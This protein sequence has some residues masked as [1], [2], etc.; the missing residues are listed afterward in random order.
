MKKRNSVIILFITIILVSMAYNRFEWPQKDVNIKDT[1]NYLEV[2]SPPIPLIVGVREGPAVIDPIDSWDSASTNVIKQVAECLWWYNLTDP[3]LPLEGLLATAWNY[4]ANNKVLDVH[5]RESV[6]FHDGSVLN[7]TVVKWNLERINYFI[8]ATG[9]LPPTTVPAFP[10]SIYFLP[11]GSSIMKSVEVLDDYLVRITLNDV[12]ASFIPLMSYTGSAMISMVS[13]SATEYIDLTTDDL[14]GTGPFVYDGYETDIEVNFH[15]FENYWNGEA[16]IT[17]LVFKV[18]YESSIRNNAMLNKEIHFLDGVDPDFVD[19]FN[20]D[21]DIVNVEVGPDLIYW[22]YAFDTWR[23][24]VTWR[25][26][27]SKAYNYTYVIEE[28]R[29]G[30]AVR[31][32]P[33]VPSGMPGHDPTVVVAQYNIAEARLIMQS[34]GFGVGWDI[35]THVAG[36]FTPGA[37][38]ALWEAANFRH[39]EMNH[40]Q[41]SGNSRKLN[42][43]LTYDLNRIGVTTNETT[44][45]WDQFLTAGEHGD[46][47]GIWYVGWGPDYPDAF[48]MLDPLFNPTSA[49]NFVNLSDAQVISWLNDAAAETNIPTRNA[50]FSD[51]QHRLF[52]L[53]YVHMPLW[54]TLTRDVHL[55]YLTNYPYNSLESSIIGNLYFYPC[56]WDPPSDL[57]PFKIFIDDAIPLY[58]WEATAS[59]YDWCF[60]SGTWNDPYIIQDLELDG[61]DTL[62]CIEI[63]NSDVYFEIRNCTI[64]SSLEH[65]IALTNVNNSMI[66][67]NTFQRNLDRAIYSEFSNN[68]SIYDNFINTSHYGF[69]LMLSNVNM[70]SDNII[71]NC[72]YGFYVMNGTNNR[73]TENYLYR[74]IIGIVDANGFNNSLLENTAIESVG[75][76]IALGGSVNATVSMN[77]IIGSAMGGIILQ[78]SMYSFISN[79]NVSQNGDFGIYLMGLNG[80]STNN[81]ISQNKITNNS[82][83]GLGLNILT[84]DNLVFNNEFINNGL[85]AQDNGTFNLWDNGA[86]GNSWDDYVGEDLNDDGIGDVA[87][88]ILGLAGNIDNYPIFDDGAEV[89][90]NITIITPSSQALHA[91]SAPSF[92]LSINCPKLDSSWYTIDNDITNITFIGSTGI[93]D[94][95]EWDKKGNG[96]VTIRFYANNTAGWIAYSEVVIN[97]DIISPAITIINPVG[98][99]LFGTNPPTYNIN[100]ND[101]NLDIMW[102]TLDN[103]VTNITISELTG[104]IDETEWNN[105]PSGSITIRFY[106]SD[107]LGN[108]GYSE[109]VINK[110][111]TPPVITINS[112][113]VGDIFETNS[114]IYS[115]AVSDAN[116]DTMWY[117]L[118][119]GATNISISDLIGVIDEA[120]WNDQPNGYVTIRFYAN[121]TMG[122]EGTAL[123]IVTKNAPLPEVPPGIPGT[124]LFVIYLTLFIGI[125]ILIWQ[126]EKKIKH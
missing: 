83:T 100:I 117:T 1:E 81:I 26:A 42:D 9:T 122:G 3:D 11:N 16:N 89:L 91:D 72:M 7:A 64:S 19:Q 59:Y 58:N 115:I 88:D 74:N 124:N 25:E 98:G 13:H 118:D 12:F 85:N 24:N 39:L 107:A 70:L 34:M 110:D 103:G 53:L 60:G 109:V 86:L 35:G 55:V 125:P 10:A 6:Y 30:N 47:R 36:V 77:H 95:I 113:E 69:D 2:S 65:G 126:I 101:A 31:G 84:K 106:A 51:L 96:T 17:N 92:S 61:G 21:P 14:V 82:E 112:P 23:V 94:Q 18:I 50:L 116:L 46:L 67:N 121:D 44:R 62:N 32:P 54:A 119:N 90:P 41:G 48:N 71:Q 5:I 97:K 66:Y 45:D 68:N 111:I 87:Y 43:L 79:N 76:G 15:A 104:I 99:N 75:Y 63:Y 38:E 22:Y 27:I 73:V 114:P 20:A 49:S 40:H 29:Q 33:A 4:S 123:V 93:I 37:D 105:Q 28:I 102:Y 80:E 56:I 52:E 108:I 78:D 57:V 120:E 8:N